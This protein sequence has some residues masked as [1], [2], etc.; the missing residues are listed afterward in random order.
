[1]SIGGHGFTPKTPARVKKAMD[2]AM[3]YRKKQAHASG[4]DKHE[5]D[6][7]SWNEKLDDKFAHAS[8]TLNL[9]FQEEKVGKVTMTLIELSTP[10][11]HQASQF[12]QNLQVSHMSPWCEHII[13]VCH[14]RSKKRERMQEKQ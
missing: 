9:S 12:P 14:V 1:M 4:V 6:P 13:I 3:A 7:C 2:A 10:L 5:K 8:Q 11:S